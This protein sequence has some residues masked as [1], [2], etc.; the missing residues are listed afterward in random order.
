MKK[1]IAIAMMVMGIAIG[2]LSDEP[3]QPIPERVRI[4][5]PP[6]ANREIP[7][8]VVKISGSEWEY[9]KQKIK[10]EGEYMFKKEKV[11]LV[12]TNSI[13]FEIEAFPRKETVPRSHAPA[14]GKKKPTPPP[15]PK[16]YPGQNI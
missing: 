6:T 3:Y 2:G 12:V 5:R 1:M 9:V 11:L 10:E 8:R 13:P 16:P 7:T 15:T 4:R 14:R